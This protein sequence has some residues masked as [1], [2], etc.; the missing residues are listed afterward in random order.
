MVLGPTASGKSDL[1]VRLAK[2][3]NGEVVSADSRQVY[4]GMDIGTGTITKK[5][6]QRIPHHL[7][8]VASP[9]KIFDVAQWKK[10]ADAA[11]AGIIRRGKLPIVCGGTGLYI[12]AL[13]ENIAYPDVPPDWKLRV[14]L[15]KKTT[16][17]LFAL[18]KKLDPA[19][20]QAIDQHNPRRL[21]RAIEIVKNTGKAVPEKN[22]KPIYDTLLLGVKKSDAELKKRIHARLLARMKK[23]MVKEAKKLHEGGLSWKR[24]EQLGLEYKYLALFLQKKMDKRA[25][26]ETLETKIGQYA[27]RQMTW[28][29]AMHT[30]VWIASE[31]EAENKTKKFL[32]GRIRKRNPCYAK[33][34]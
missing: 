12:K 13:I 15:E 34:A 3:F 14:A 16:K 24:M 25:M 21:I 17:Q 5:E 28:F 22:I 18:L 26:T 11:I 8:S 30:I 29:R 1:A 9:K 4:R 33:I 32:D 2:T 20:A 7:L 27:K 31:K 23:G 19:R 6:M 10:K